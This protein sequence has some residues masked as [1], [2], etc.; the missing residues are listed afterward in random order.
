MA[1][2]Y[3][4]KHGATVMLTSLDRD[5]EYRSDEAAE[6]Y[7]ARSGY[8]PLALYAVLQK[9]TALGTQSAQPGAVV[10]D[11]S[12]AGRA[13]GPHRPPRLCRARSSTPSAT[14]GAAPRDCLGENENGLP[15]PGQAVDRVRSAR[16][17][18]EGYFTSR[19][20]NG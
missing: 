4:R 11:P 17:G 8:N 6:I 10:Q 16:C 15:F 20:V 1:K 5:A 7:L 12:A 13:A 2:E 3:V 9:M 14:S 19:S 18:R